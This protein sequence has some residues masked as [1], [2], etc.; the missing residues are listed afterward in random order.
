M[1]KL[2]TGAAI[3]AAFLALMG[4]EPPK[5][6]GKAQAATHR[7]MIQNSGDYNI[8]RNWHPKLRTAAAKSGCEYW[9]LW[10][11]PGGTAGADAVQLVHKKTAK[12][13]TVDLGKKYTFT[14]P[15]PKT[16]K[17]VVAENQKGSTFVTKGCS[18]WYGS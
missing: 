14:Y 9:V 3:V 4:C 15:H 7:V 8:T 5:K 2:I 18:T 6:T 11:I 1:K 13:A 12:I 10:D 16:G 17:K